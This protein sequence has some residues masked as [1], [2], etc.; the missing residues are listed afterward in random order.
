MFGFLV[1]DK[2]AGITSRTALN[3]VSAIVK[4]AKAGHAG[5]LDPL[6]T[7]VLVLCI[8]PATRLVGLVQGMHKK[9]RARFRV[10]FESE[11]EDLGSPLV[12]VAD[13][14][15]IFED[16]LLRVLRQFEGK[17]SQKPPRYSALRMHGRRAYDLARAGRS[18]EL[19]PREV[20]I[21]SIQLIE[22]DGQE[23]ELDIVCGSG[24]YIRSLGRDI[25]RELGCGA[26]MTSLRR[27]EIGA[28]RLEDAVDVRSWNL[29]A[30]PDPVSQH[31]IS[32]KVALV[33]GL[34]LPEAELCDDDLKDLWH[35]RRLKSFSERFSAVAASS[36]T[37]VMGVDR[38]GR[39]MAIFRRDQDS[40]ELSVD[41]S[42]AR[43]WLPN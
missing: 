11:T 25:G 42:F 31:L 36:H 37:S 8:G 5:T 35:G 28:F 6:A 43:Y 30:Q 40:N 3:A 16:D 4:P 17:I 29:D 26:V 7:G 24:T 15:P 23:F 21:D 22:F 32:P 2:P 1:I 12:P 27:T 33:R 20:S 14:R 13:A 41:I 18:F 10:G 34:G 39:L 19:A 38:G 9:Y